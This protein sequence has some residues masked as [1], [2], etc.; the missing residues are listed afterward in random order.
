MGQH[1]RIRFVGP[2]CCFINCTSFTTF[3]KTISFHGM[4]T[5]EKKHVT[6]DLCRPKQLQTILFLIYIFWGKKKENIF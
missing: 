1:F 6:G 5:K 4:T 2:Y 3:S